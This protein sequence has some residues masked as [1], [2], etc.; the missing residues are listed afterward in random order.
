MT[1]VRPRF[2][3][4][5]AVVG[6]F[7]WGGACAHPTQ[8]VLNLTL[9]GLPCETGT[10]PSGKSITD[11]VI[12]VGADQAELD[13]RERDHVVAGSI[14]CADVVG[15][16]NIVLYPSKS[17]HAFVRVVAGTKQEVDGTFDRRPAEQCTSGSDGTC[18]R[19]TRSFD[20]VEHETIELAMVLDASC[21]G[22]VCPDQQTCDVGGTCGSID[23]GLRAD[24]KK[25]GVSPSDASQ[26]DAGREFAF[27]CAGGVVKWNSP[28]C[29][30]NASCY[31]PASNSLVCGSSPS[32]C[33]DDDFLPCCELPK[34]GGIGRK[35]CLS[36]RHGH[37]IRLKG[38]NI[39]VAGTGAVCSADEVCFPDEPN[40]CLLN[41]VCVPRG[42]SGWGTCQA[43]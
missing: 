20:Y 27:T 18:L 22:K 11:L 42:A 31:R 43:R 24:C 35:C 19:S 29:P 23:C 4:T 16:A 17:M 3:V 5:L 40:T 12:Y 41:R 30:Q 8:A 2:F 21:V 32:A 9:Q 15:N 25:G 39:S 36:L 28:T 6:C 13:A 26:V 38:A 34:E 14:Q 37:P 10:G 1:R 33:F 7:L